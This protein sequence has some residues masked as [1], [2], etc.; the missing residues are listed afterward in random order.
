V[1][2]ERN[3]RPS[4]RRRIGARVGPELVAIVLIVVLALAVVAGIRMGVLPLP[5]LPR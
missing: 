3:R 2:G 4:L 1:T 5:P